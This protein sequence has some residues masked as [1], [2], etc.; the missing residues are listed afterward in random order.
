MVGYIKN[1]LPRLQQYSKRLD[2]TE[3]FVGRSWL[4]LDEDNNA[5]TYEFLRDG[6]LVMSVARKG[7]D[8]K[9]VIGSWELLPSERL[10]VMRPE[11]VVLELGFLGDGLLIFLESGASKTPFSLYDPKI[12]PDGDIEWYLNRF[13][14]APA[15]AKKLPEQ[16]NTISNSSDRLYRNADGSLFTGTVLDKHLEYSYLIIE[17]GLLTSSFKKVDYATNKGIITIHQH[18]SVPN[19]SEKAYVQDGS[20]PNDGIYLLENNSDY[21]EFEIIDG[22][23][24]EVKWDYTS[25]ITVGLIILGLF[26]IILLIGSF[27]NSN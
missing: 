7:A 2:K 18:Y 27:N 6:R 16:I 15:A 22:V 9:T 21:K 3:N 13:L 10:L 25:Q 24:K 1:L 12:I 20:I 17:D 8:Q 5:H 11:P 19:I 4:L 26:I 14:E 23:L